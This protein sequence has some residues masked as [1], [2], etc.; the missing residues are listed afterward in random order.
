[1]RVMFELVVWS[2]PVGNIAIAVRLC[3]NI[4]CSGECY[5][6]ISFTVDRREMHRGTES[7]PVASTC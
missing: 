7:G 4:H 6:S 1:M 3:V 2:K 5:W